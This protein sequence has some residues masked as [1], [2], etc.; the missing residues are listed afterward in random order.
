MDSEDIAKRTPKAGSAAA[1]KAAIARPRDPERTKAAILKAARDEFCEQGF[2]GA[3]VD[4]I[5]ERARA[6]KRLLY[7]YW[8]N[9]EALY[10]AVLLDAYREIRSGERE[11]RISQYDPVEGVDRIIRFTFRHF[12]ANPW[13]PRL[14]SVENLQNAKFVKQ[15]ENLDEIRS[16]IVGELKELIRR[17]GA[18]GVFRVDVD[19]M[20]LYIS[21]ISLCYFYVSNMQTLSVVF[22]QDLSQFSM[23]QDREAQAVQMVLD[24]LRTR[25]A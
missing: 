10:L 20:Q 24:Y 17:G 23:I 3:R 18:S 22:G 7:H 8:G 25:R 16:P 6:N 19:P 21:I 4:A 13:F 9:K 15:I 12:L 14:L 1:R 11:L 5:A 2:N